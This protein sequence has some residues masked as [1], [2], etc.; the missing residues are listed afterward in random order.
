MCG[1]FGD[2]F[3]LLADRLLVPAGASTESWTTRSSSSSASRATTLDP[4]P[5][6]RW[7]STV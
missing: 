4:P 7:I 5:L 2:G 6:D 3:E 1:P